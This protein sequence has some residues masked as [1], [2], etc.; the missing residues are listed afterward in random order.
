M[1][2][3]HP[4]VLRLIGWAGARLLRC[5]IR[6]L[7]VRVHSEVPAADP[8]TA[9]QGF[10]Y[11][12]WHE[13]IL[14]PAA[15]FGYR[16]IHLLISQHHDGEYI[17]RIVQ[18]LGFAVV[19]GSTTR[20]AVR[21]VRELGRSANSANL[22]ITPDGPRGPRRVLQNGAVYLASRGGLAIVPMGYAFDRPWRASSWDRFVLPRPFTRA[23]CFLGTPI[24]V[25]RDADAALLAHHHRLVSDAM[26]RATSQA[27]LLLA[28]RSLDDVGLAAAPVA[29]AAL[30]GRDDRR[31][32]P[33]APHRDLAPRLDRKVE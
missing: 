25:P 20:G 19:R 27:E 13:T 22:A 26:D 6:T 8:R 30:P 10:L 23:A 16:G 5:W 9:T 3:E 7:R 31:H 12:L 24:P 14:M 1:K 21:A 4:S 28:G 29:A 11:C 32:L 2:I 17:S 33:R 18:Q 15:V